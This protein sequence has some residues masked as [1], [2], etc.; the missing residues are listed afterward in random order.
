MS[1]PR[2]V[3]QDNVTIMDA[4]TTSDVYTFVDFP[5][6]DIAMPEIKN[7]RVTFRVRNLTDAI[8]AQWAD[9]GHPDQVLLG[10]PRTYEVAASTKW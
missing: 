2:V 7:L 9:P 6:Q 8:Y 5:G 1:G 4:Y 10:A 3:Y